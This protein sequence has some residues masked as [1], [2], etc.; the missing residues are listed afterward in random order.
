MKKILPHSRYHARSVPRS[1]YCSR[2]RAIADYIK[3]IYVVAVVF[4]HRLL[5]FQWVLIVHH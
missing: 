3:L 5:V 4:I 2:T 1:R